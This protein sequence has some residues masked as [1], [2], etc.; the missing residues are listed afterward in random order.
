VAGKT[1][2]TN[3]YHDAWFVGFT[4]DIVAGVWVGYDTPR[5]LGAPASE[6]ALPVWAKVTS[7][8]LEGVPPTPFES[9]HDLH[10][11]WIDP[12]SGRLSGPGCASTMRVPF[13][14]GTAPVDSCQADHAAEWLARFEKRAADSLAALARRAAQAPGGLDSSSV[15]ARPEPGG[16]D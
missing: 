3:D 8:L 4:P 14:P 7:R 6:V 13:L 11:A 16:P 1:G 5:T 2:T 10:L 9:G 15:S 12:W